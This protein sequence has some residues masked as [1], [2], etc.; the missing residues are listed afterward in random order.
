[1][2]MMSRTAL[3]L[4]ALVLAAATAATAATAFA[5]TKQKL[6]RP[7]Q[8]VVEA[9]YTSNDVIRQTKARTLTKTY[10]A[11]SGFKAPIVRR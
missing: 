4:M 2:T 9:I 11:D 8:A 6:P 3:F 7:D 10:R 5:A 1:M